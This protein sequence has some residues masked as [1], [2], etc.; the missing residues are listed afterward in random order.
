MRRLLA[1]L[2]CS[3]P[4]LATAGDRPLTLEAI[5]G[6]PG[7]GTRE[8]ELVR[9]LPDGSALLLRLPT[10]D[11]GSQLVVET[12]DGSRRAV[13]PDWDALVEG[14]RGQ[15]PAWQ[16]PPVTPIEQAAPHRVEPVLS[17]DG[18]TLVWPEAGEL[19]QLDLRSGEAVLLTEGGGDE[20]WPRWSPDGRRLAFV[21]DFSLWVLDPASGVERRL[22]D[23]GGASGVRD[24]VPDWVAEEELG[25]EQSYWWSPDGR[26]IAFLRYDTRPVDLLPQV[27]ALSPVPSVESQRYSRPGRPNAEVRLGVVD[28]DGGGPVWVDHG[29]GECYLPRAGFLGDG[30]RLWYLWLARDQRSLELRLADPGDGRTLATVVGESH[31]AFVELGPDPVFT[32]DGRLLWTSERDGWRHLELYRLDGTLE[33]RL[34][35]GEWE[36]DRVYGLAGDRVVYRSTAVDPRQRHLFAV[37]LGGGEA[38]RLSAEPGTHDATLAPDG[39][40]LLDDWS[41]LEVPPR[42]TLVRADG[43]GARLVHDGAPPDLDAFRR[44]PVT[45]GTLAADDGTVL[46]TAIVVP[47]GSEPARRHPA[48][49]YVYG[50]PHSQDV[51]DEWMGTRGLYLEL[52]AQR[53]FVVFWLD[54]RGTTGRGKAFAAA[55]AGALGEVETAD[56]L[57]GVRH[58]RS[59]ELVDG[60][61]IAVYGGS[62][63]GFMTLACLAEAPEMLAAGIAYAPV[64]DW[65]LY[66]SA[67][68]ERYMGTPED[69][70]EGYRAS[71]ILER[72][73]RIADPVLLAFGSLD[74]NVHPKNSLE[75]VDR[76]A[77]RSAEVELM[78]YPRVRHPVRTSRF[79]LHFHELKLDFLERR[80]RPPDGAR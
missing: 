48:V 78:V 2:A 31:P 41:S 59:L 35:S 4:L 24:A 30:T 47:P 6:D 25:V 11:G 77:G 15:R 72:E 7:L 18:A 71:S 13:V 60:D 62:Y 49:L 38:R 28:V 5:F 61:R 66:D 26:R 44:C 58:L 53:G 34:T 36:V 56:Q 67:Y 27:D 70:P 29:G 42:L 75:L 57:A 54:N 76:L 20:L 39:R 46:Y 21:R 40:H 33:R 3:F 8:P 17:P 73:G 43:G 79:K 74:N 10:D 45:M 64:T 50:G 23:H 12:L 9:W 65:S 68:T 51:V 63:G 22:T 37:P 52:L 14:L 16:K 32:A 55:V 80:L 1:A 19:A 69:N